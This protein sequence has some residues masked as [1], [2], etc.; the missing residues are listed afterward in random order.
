MLSSSEKVKG[1]GGGLGP[2]STHDEREILRLRR[3]VSAYIFYLS[4]DCHV[5]LSFYDLFVNLKLLLT[6]GFFAVSHGSS[7]S[8]IAILYSVISLSVELLRFIMGVSTTRIN[9]AVSD[10]LDLAPMN[11]VDDLLRRRASEEVSFP[12]VTFPWTHKDEPGFRT[13]TANQLSRYVDAVAAS[14][15]EQGLTP[16]VSMNLRQLASVSGS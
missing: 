9:T 2:S 4:S 15:I 3:P 7:Y 8:F 5:F 14:F 11:F 13:L 6:V 1:C 10:S 16:A 12:L